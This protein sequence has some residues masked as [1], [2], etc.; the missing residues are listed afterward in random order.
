MPRQ[1]TLSISLLLALLFIIPASN[2]QVP[3]DLM[4]SFTKLTSKTDKFIG[5][6][7]PWM[8]EVKKNESLIPGNVRQQCDSFSKAYGE[9]TAKVNLA[10]ADPTKLTGDLIGSL[11]GDLGKLST[12]FSG[13]QKQFKGLPFMK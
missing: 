11:S 6:V 8:G 9:Y 3:A 7:D 4:K 13:L 12:Q 10:K 1:L 5:K 2:A